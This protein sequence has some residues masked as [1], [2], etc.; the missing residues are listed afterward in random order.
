M[1]EK[2]EQLISD[3]I[4]QEEFTKSAGDFSAENMREIQ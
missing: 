4:M 1:M 3:V 2:A